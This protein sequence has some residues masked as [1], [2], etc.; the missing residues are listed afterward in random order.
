MPEVITEKND[1][2]F[3]DYS[4]AALVSAITIAKEVVSLKEEIAQLKQQIAEL[5]GNNN[6]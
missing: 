5:K 1:T 4:S 6:E 3:M 2:M